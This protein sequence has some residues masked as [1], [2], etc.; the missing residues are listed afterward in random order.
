MSLS[1]LKPVKIRIINPIKRV[2]NR[3]ILNNLFLKLK[4]GYFN[5]LLTPIL[6]HVIK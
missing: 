2:I 6:N 3:L 4:S 5:D 1:A